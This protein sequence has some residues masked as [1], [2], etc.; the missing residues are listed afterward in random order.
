MSLGTSLESDILAID[1]GSSKA[2]AAGQWG[3]ALESYAG[4]V[5]PALAAGVMD[6]AKAALETALESA[7]GE[8]SASSSASSME[9]A[10]ASFASTMAGGMSPDFTG[11]PP[12][13]DVGFL[14]LLDTNKA[15]KAIAAAD[16]A[17]AIDT[18]MRTGLA[19][20]AGGPPPPPILWS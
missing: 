13:D 9:S 1:G 2:D 6:S 10:F 19:Q 3:D 7:F 18:W 16:W 20:I 8:A 5:V 15:T 12:P 17:S 11:T 4:G 14:A